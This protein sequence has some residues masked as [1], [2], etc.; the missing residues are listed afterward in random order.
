MS[1]RCRF[2]PASFLC[3][4]TWQLLWVHMLWLATQKWKRQHL[5][6]E[7]IKGCSKQNQKSSSLEMLHARIK[8][9]D[10]IDVFCQRSSVSSLFHSIFPLSR[11]NLGDQIMISFLKGKKKSFLKLLQRTSADVLFSINLEA[12]SHFWTLHFALWVSQ[13]GRRSAPE[14]QC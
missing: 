14:S 5:D 9:Y 2:K 6:D 8:S 12:N 3:S 10:S 7:R 1:L 4:L 13:P 11:F